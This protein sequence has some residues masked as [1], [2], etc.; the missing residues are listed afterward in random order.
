MINIVPAIGIGYSVSHPISGG[1]GVII[2]LQ[3]DV[4]RLYPN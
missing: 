4:G 3:P 2:G 1:S